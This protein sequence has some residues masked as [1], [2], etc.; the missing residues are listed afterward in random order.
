M[1]S[2]D[3]ANRLS[4]LR[5]INWIYLAG[6]KPFWILLLAWL[7]INLIMYEYAYTERTEYTPCTGILFQAIRDRRQREPRW[8]C[9]EGA[10]AQLQGGSAAY[11]RGLLS[12]GPRASPEA[13][14]A[15]AS[16]GG[17]AGARPPACA[18]RA[19]RAESHW[20]EAKVDET[21]AST[22]GEA[23]STTGKARGRCWR[24]WKRHWSG[25]PIIY[26]HGTCKKVKDWWL[27]QLNLRHWMT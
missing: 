22:Y 15:R 8:C 19:N 18:A 20:R 25:V 4:N 1:S 23:T 17:E 24:W 3:I 26:S 14:A 2:K 10:A 13:G 11:W 12:R 7:Q 27:V 6:C 9:P 21:D 5:T 16:G